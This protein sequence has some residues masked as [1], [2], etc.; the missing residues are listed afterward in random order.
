MAQRNR[1]E[2]LVRV[3]VWMLLAACWTS[4]SC[5]DAAVEGFTG[6]SVML[7]CSYSG[8]LPQKVDAFWRN[9]NTKVVLDIKDGGQNFATQDQ[10]Y[11]GRVSSFPDQYQKGNFSIILENLQLED[12]GTYECI[13]LTV[14]YRWKVNLKVSEKAVTERSTPGPPSGGA[15]GT[16]LHVFLL[17]ALCLLLCF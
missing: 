14:N 10:R 5:Q 13:I 1:M 12:A 3:S 9:G 4:V 11:K 8:S 15:A 2:A 16:N 6:G 7:P 17:S